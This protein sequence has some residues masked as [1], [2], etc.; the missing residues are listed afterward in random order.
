MNGDL[1][2]EY[3]RQRLLFFV[4]Q[5][6]DDEIAAAVKQTVHD[7]AAA[8]WLL[9][10]PVFVDRVDDARSTSV[11]TEDRTVGGALEILGT[12]ANTLPKDLDAA[13]FADVDR[14]VQAVRALSAQWSL[15]VEFELDGACVGAIEDGV[16]DRSLAEGL[17]GE[18]R[19]HLERA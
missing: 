12:A 16:L 3:A 5:D 7:L 4:A 6:V 13:T 14:V 11:D 10:P 15:E 9:A 18:W 19:R 8:T 17:L 2:R 1:H